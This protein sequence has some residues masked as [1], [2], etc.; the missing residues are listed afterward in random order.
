MTRDTENFATKEPHVELA[1][2]VHQRDPAS[3]PHVGDRIPY[4]IVKSTKV[5]VHWPLLTKRKLSKMM[6]I[7]AIQGARNWEKSEDP[8]YALEN[9]IPIDAQYYLEHHIQKP[10]SRIFDPILKNAE[11]ELFNGEHTRSISQP[12]PTTG[13]IVK[14]AKI[15]ASCLGCRA[16]IE[17]SK[18]NRALCK[19]CQPNETELYHKSLVK[20]TD[21]ES[22]FTRL[23]SQC[24]RCQGSLHQDILCSCKDCPIFYRRKKVMKDLGEAQKTL[25][26]FDEW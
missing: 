24:Q 12:T 9:N 20:V 2:R 3:A 10:L 19:H 14:F 5:R 8:I 23:W 26:R 6:L 11:R 4:V 21:L 15:K 7:C 1:K 16:P 13:G 17:D 22:Q 18:S 25:A